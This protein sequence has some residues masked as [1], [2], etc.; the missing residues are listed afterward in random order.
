MPQ[1]RLTPFSGVR[2]LRLRA[3]PYFFVLMLLTLMTVNLCRAE[4]DSRVR[5][6]AVLRAEKAYN[7]LSRK[8]RENP[9]NLEVA[10][11]LSRAC[12]DH[13]EFAPNDETRAQ[14]GNEGVAAARKAIALNTTNGA[15]HYYL[16][17]NLGQ[18]ARTKSLGALKIVSEM[19]TEFI[20]A[21]KYDEKLDCGGPDRSLGLLY[22]NSPAWPISIGNRIKAR[23]HLQRALD[24]APDFPENHLCLIEA[25]A[26]W[27]EYARVTPGVAK[28]REIWPAAEKRYSSEE[29]TLSWVDWKQRLARVQASGSREKKLPSR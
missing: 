11:Q 21:R 9:E 12:F 2:N 14:I 18:V 7:E 23:D 15:A 26:D 4:E 25:M 28:L 5:T 20:L 27:K 10:W 3:K 29:Y 6:N 17:M 24:L 22:L 13:A 8:H 19:E 16:G 1:N